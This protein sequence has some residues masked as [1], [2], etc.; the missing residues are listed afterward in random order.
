MKKNAVSKS[1]CSA[2]FSQLL[3]KPDGKVSPCCYLYH[4]NLGNL[5]E[6]SLVDIWNDKPIQKMRSEFLESVPKPCRS[7][8]KYLRCNRF[9]QHLDKSIER[10][11]IQ[12]APPNK[13]DLRLNG[14]C[15]LSCVMCDVWRAPNA[16][17]DQ[18]SFWEQGPKEVFPFLKEIEVLGGEPFI[19]KDT[20]KLI[21][22]VSEAN[23][24]C[25]WSFV[26]N[27][28]YQFSNKLNNA[29][30]PLRLKQ[31]Q[32]SLDSLNPEVYGH[33]RKGGDLNITLKTIERFVN[34]RKGYR[35]RF[36]D[37]FT[38]I[39][40]MCVLKSNRLEVPQFIAF[41]Q[42]NA[43]QVQFQH[44]FYDPSGQ[45]S[46]S[47]LT[48]KEKTEYLDFLKNNV[49]PSFLPDLGPVINP[50]EDELKNKKHANS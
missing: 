21:Q 13:L 25:H 19:Q 15:N 31:I 14:Q 44:A 7:K 45:E 17:Y 33:I 22:A 6:K 4:L 1:F 40:S 42:Q 12:S 2:P 49:D 38:F 29:L 50:L 11:L 10:K 36:G 23:K 8:I 9:F 30:K 5:R 34:F 35:D 41:C 26:T 37:D 46:L 48:R 39:I 32:I 18:T 28:H 47:Y 24:N 16:I 20:Y 27:A 43:A 3:L